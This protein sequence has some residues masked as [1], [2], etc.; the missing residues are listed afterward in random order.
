M[1]L[2]LIKTDLKKAIRTIITT[3]ELDIRF[4]DEVHEI[5]KNVPHPHTTVEIQSAQRTALAY[6]ALFKYEKE[7]DFQNC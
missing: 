5:M 6:V 2:E 4:E 7:I 1:I 3:D